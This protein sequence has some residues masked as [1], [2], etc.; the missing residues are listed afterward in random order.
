MSRRLAEVLARLQAQIDK[1][2][3]QEVDRVYELRFVGLEKR[4]YLDLTRESRFVQDTAPQAAICKLGLHLEDLDALLE[5]TASMKGLLASG[6]LRIF[7]DLA[8]GMRLSK[9]FERA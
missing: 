5:G 3:A 7:G 8:D 9:L 1:E 4:W 6:R 2:R